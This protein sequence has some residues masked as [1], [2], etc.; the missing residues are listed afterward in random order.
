[1]IF[2]EEFVGGKNLQGFCSQFRGRLCSWSSLLRVSTDQEWLSVSNRI[3][4]SQ[5]SKNVS[6][7][8]PPAHRSQSAS[9]VSIQQNVTIHST[10][11]QVEMKVEARATNISE[12]VNAGRRVTDLLKSKF[13][14]GPSKVSTNEPSPLK[15]NKSV[16]VIG[17]APDRLGG[18]T[19]SRMKPSDP[20]PKTAAIST[21]AVSNPAADA[22]I[23][24]HAPENLG[25]FRILRKATPSTDKAA[26]QAAKDSITHAK[27]DEHSP[28]DKKSSTQPS[29]AKSDAITAEMSKLSIKSNGTGLQALSEAAG[30]IPLAAMQPEIPAALLPPPYFGYVPVDPQLMLAAPLHGQNTQIRP[31]SKS[32]RHDPRPSNQQKGSEN[33]KASPKKTP[34]AATSKRTNTKPDVPVVASKPQAL[35]IPSKVILKRKPVVIVT[36]V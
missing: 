33:S 20:I 35:I 21:D 3:S 6:T 5:S 12:A 30:N 8:Q 29:P 15:E 9:S 2:D 31:R 27:I 18:F 4:K 25:G 13:Q 7:N 19:I 32:A 36:P 23:I 22:P 10:Q 1:M 11:K 17:K 24:S 28:K 26:T 14:N 34:P 16:E